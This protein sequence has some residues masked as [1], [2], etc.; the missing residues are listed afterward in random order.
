MEFYNRKFYNRKGERVSRDE[1][2]TLSRNN[3]SVG[4]AEIV[5]DTGDKVEISTVFL[6]LN[7]N[8]YG[9]GPPLIYETMIFGGHLN[10]ECY[11]YSTEQ[12]AAEGHMANV[13]RASAMGDGKV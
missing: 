3:R 4:F 1:Y 6:G 7:H 10:G 9:E 11:R 13:E 2:M 5:F 12:Q 8:Y